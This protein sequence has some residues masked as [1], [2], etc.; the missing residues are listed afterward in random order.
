MIPTE[1]TVSLIQVSYQLNTQ[2][3]DKT[4][5]EPDAN[6][7]DGYIYAESFLEFV[8]LLPTNVIG[9]FVHFIR[10]WDLVEVASR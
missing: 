7:L 4:V 6:K 5:D 10:K 2:S 3:N 9:A 1:S 8:G